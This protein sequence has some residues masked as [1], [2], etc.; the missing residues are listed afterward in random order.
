[1]LAA[2]A[3]QAWG[4]NRSIPSRSFQMGSCDARALVAKTAVLTGRRVRGHRPAQGAPMPWAAVDLEE[5][6]TA[7]SGN[8]Y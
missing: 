5:I 2:R 3:A 1:M 7:L 8:P 4:M 6:R